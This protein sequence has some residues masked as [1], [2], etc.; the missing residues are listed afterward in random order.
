MSWELRL[1]DCLDPATGLASLAN[2]S[3]DHVITD[4][5][6]SERVHS[7]GRRQAPGA[8][9][10]IEARPLGFA[11]I[12]DELRLITSSEFARI[13]C[14]W[15]LAFGDAEGS[16]GWQVA[17]EKAG[18]EL[19]RIGAWV[20]LGGTPQFTG[21]RPGA[22]FEA[23]YVGHRP[24]RKRWNGG[25]KVGIWTH[26][27]VKNWEGRLHTTQKPIALMESLIR[28]F[29]DP[30]DLV[31]DPFA[32]SGTTGVACIRL[33]RRFIGW[34]R[35]PKFHAAAFK[36]L[37]ETHEQPELMSNEAFRREAKKKRKQMGLGLE[38]T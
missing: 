18:L 24:G 32:G 6:Y 36:R 3:V 26:P 10:I 2:G 20:R 28:D 17:Y 4:P 7:K 25:G 23:I 11:A 1:G 12:T 14:R 9:P 19:C 5:P 27:I 33:G 22:G 21:D 15:V 8:G 37:S 34:E 38:E 35:D 31:V 30:G 29:T 16:S 13:A